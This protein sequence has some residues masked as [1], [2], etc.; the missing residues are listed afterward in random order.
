MHQNI[1]PF[2]AGTPTGSFG[3]LLSMRAPTSSF[4]IHC[5]HDNSKSTVAKIQNISLPIQNLSSK[6]NLAS[7]RNI[8]SSKPTSCRV[9]IPIPRYGPTLATRV[10]ILSIDMEN[11]VQ[12]RQ[13]GHRGCMRST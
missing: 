1:L 10:P 8:W 12:S 2:P 4:D 5:T 3:H 9:G 11:H 7:E 13:I 6:S